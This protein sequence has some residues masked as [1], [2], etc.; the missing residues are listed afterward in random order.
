MDVSVATGLDPLRDPEELFDDL[1]LW[2][3]DNGYIRID[4][5][6]D[7]GNFYGVSLTNQGFA[8]LGGQPDGLDRPLGAKMKEAASSVGGEIRSSVISEL[9]GTLVGAAAKQFVL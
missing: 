1:V 9:I 5:N 2:L 4:Q 6:G 7:S 8:V 3:H